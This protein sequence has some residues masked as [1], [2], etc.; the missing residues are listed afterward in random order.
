MSDSIHRAAVV[1]LQ[2]QRTNA[3]PWNLIRKIDDVHVVNL[4]DALFKERQRFQ[5]CTEQHTCEPRHSWDISRTMKIQIRRPTNVYDSA[6][7]VFGESESK[8]TTT[9]KKTMEIPLR[10]KS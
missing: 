6:T 9:I 8:C 5:N 7:N 1:P 2:V 3:L 10:K 4:F